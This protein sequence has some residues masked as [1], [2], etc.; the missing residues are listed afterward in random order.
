M[1]LQAEMGRIPTK[2]CLSFCLYILYI[3]SQQANSKTNT[4]NKD[5]HKHLA[6]YY[7]IGLPVH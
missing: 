5:S 4:V 3:I 7:C 1:V 2:E 6:F